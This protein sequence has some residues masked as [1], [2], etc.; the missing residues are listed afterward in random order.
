MNASDKNKIA[1]AVALYF[2]GLYH[3]DVARLAEVFHPKA[4]YVCATQTPLV[5]K[6]MEEYFPI[7]AAREAPASRNEP[8]AD[9]LVSIEFAGP[10]TAFVKAYCRIGPKYF[11]DFLTLI[12]VDGSWKIISKVFHYE[13]DA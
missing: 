7:V 13:L 10:H 9:E 11:T 2:D 3:S 8:R 4:I 5:Y 12:H 1:Q 6:T